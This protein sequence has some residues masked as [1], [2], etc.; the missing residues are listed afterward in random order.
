LNIGLSTS[1][2]PQPNWSTRRGSPEA[3]AH[4]VRH[5]LLYTLPTDADL[6]DAVARLS[7]DQ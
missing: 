4:T 3:S 7:A 6:E 5:T 1:S 2:P